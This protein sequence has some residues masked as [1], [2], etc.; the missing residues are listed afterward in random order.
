MPAFFVEV[1]A[2]LLRKSTA[3][4]PA[5]IDASHL[6]YSRILAAEYRSPIPRCR[7]LGLSRRFAENV[8]RL[9]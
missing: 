9:F 8:V 6:F 2:S 3:A 5:R 1:A 4:I 7:R